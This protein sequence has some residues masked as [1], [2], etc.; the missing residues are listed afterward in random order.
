MFI[1]SPL[2]WG[3]HI[4]P[5]NPT[6]TLEGLDPT[7]IRVAVSRFGSGSHLMA[8][9]FAHTMGWDPAHLKFVAVGGLRG[10]LAAF[11]EEGAEGSNLLF[12]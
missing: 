8:Y 2:Q 4:H 5:S 10:A 7:K 3:V 6:S 9:V 11:K 12:Y 1:E